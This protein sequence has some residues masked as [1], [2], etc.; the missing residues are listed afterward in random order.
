MPDALPRT[1]L[2]TDK[3]AAGIRAAYD[4][5]VRRRSFFSARTTQ[6]RYLERVREWVEKLERG[7][8]AEDEAVD[9]LQKELDALGYDPEAGGFPGDEGVPPAKAGGLT[10]L[11]S[12]ARISLVLRTNEVLGA[13]LR[14][15]AESAADPDLAADWPAWRLVRA[16]A[17]KEPRDW[18]VRWQNAYGACGGEGAHP[19]EF[20]AL[21]NS[22]IWEALGEYGDDSTGSDC[23][24]F[25][26]NSTMDWEDVPREEAVALGLLDGDEEMDLDFDGGMGD[27]EIAEA[28]SGL[29]DEDAAALAEEL[30]QWA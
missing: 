16:G 5:A 28:L 23:P 6:A 8:V 15:K 20:V 9:A 13:N 29:S 4:L 7:E 25:A 24:P 19:T 22:P 27:A 18:T 30:E 12:Q 26:Y 10:D 1:I 11:S 2:P 3:S 14:R 17:P 21:K